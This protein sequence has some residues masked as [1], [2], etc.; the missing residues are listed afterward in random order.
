VVVL[1]ET[2]DKKVKLEILALQVVMET[3]ETMV[4]KVKKAK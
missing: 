2:R 4:V 1:L 3:M